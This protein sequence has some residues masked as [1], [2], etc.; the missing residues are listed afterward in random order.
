MTFRDV[1]DL[2]PDAPTLAADLSRKT[3]VS[4]DAGRVQ[5]WRT[6]NSI[7]PEYWKGLT[8]LAKEHGFKKLTSDSLINIA[9][10]KLKAA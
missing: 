5:K 10:Q 7:P 9:R 3:G 1:V 2:W 4:I 6:R 8:Q